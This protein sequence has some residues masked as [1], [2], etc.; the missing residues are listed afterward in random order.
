MHNPISS[1][2]QFLYFVYSAASDCSHTSFLYSASNNP[3]VHIPSHQPPNF[4]FYPTSQRAPLSLSAPA[5]H[6]QMA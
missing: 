1:T 5:S 4:A 2:T 6:P 3:A